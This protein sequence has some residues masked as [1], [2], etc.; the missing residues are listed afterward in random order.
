MNEL[1]EEQEKVLLKIIE[2]LSLPYDLY[3]DGIVNINDDELLSFPS[4]IICID[5][6][7]DANDIQNLSLTEDETVCWMNM[8]YEAKLS[9]CLPSYDRALILLQ[10]AYRL[11]EEKIGNIPDTDLGKKLKINGMEFDAIMATK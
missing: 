10:N 7:I 2:T 4:A 3:D 5:S 11:I 9:N 1:N 6:Y 8:L